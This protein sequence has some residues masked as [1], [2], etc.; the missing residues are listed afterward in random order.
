LRIFA[1]CLNDLLLTSNRECE[2]GVGLGPIRPSIAEAFRNKDGIVPCRPEVP[3]DGARAEF[4]EGDDNA[5]GLAAFV[6]IYVPSP[7]AVRAP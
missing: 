7:E 1:D 4:L 3:I 5:S 2:L 6:N